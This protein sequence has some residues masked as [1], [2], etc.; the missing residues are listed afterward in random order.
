MA[1][2]GFF[3]GSIGD[4]PHPDNSLLNVLDLH[5]IYEFSRRSI[6]YGQFPV[7]VY[8]DGFRQARLYDA[9]KTFITQLRRKTRM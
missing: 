1:V 5:L 4:G 3:N 7:I 9:T 6:S 8:I 2:T